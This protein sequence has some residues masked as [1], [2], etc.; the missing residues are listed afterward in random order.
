MPFQT[1]THALPES[2]RAAMVADG[3]C[4]IPHP[5]RLWHRQHVLC[6]SYV[7]YVENVLDL[8]HGTTPRSA[9]L[10]A[11]CATAS[12]ASGWR[13]GA[14]WSAAW[15]G[16]RGQGQGQEQQAAAAAG[17]VA[18]ARW[19]SRA[20][21]CTLRRGLRAR[22]AWQAPATRCVDGGMRSAASML[23]LT[24]AHAVASMFGGA[25]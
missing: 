7:K 23:L 18:R 24:G 21:S 9:T 22:A 1:S 12:S 20:W 6:R 19:W 10:W 17:G 8:V 2:Q 11:P 25:A 13:E 16:S 4:E 15:R 5:V 14:C 3:A